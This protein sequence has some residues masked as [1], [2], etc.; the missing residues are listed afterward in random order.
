MKNQYIILLC[1]VL[2]FNLP[3][4]LHA[5]VT[6][7][8]DAAPNENALLEL[9]EDGVTTKGLLMPRVNLNSLTDPSPLT[10]HVEGIIVYNLNTTS[11]ISP[12]L[13]KNDGTRWERMQLPGNGLTGQVLEMD[14]VTMSPEWVTKYIPPAQEL[15]AYSLTKTEAFKY[16][17]GARLTANYS[18]QPY[19]ENST[20]ND[21]QWTK[22][23]NDITINVKNADNKI[24]IFLQTTLLQPGYDAGNSLSYAGGIFVNNALKG[25]RLGVISSSA[26]GAGAV[27]KTETLFFVLEDLTLGDNVLSFAF[28]RRTATNGVTALYIG[29]NMENNGVVYQ[30]STSLSYEFY[31]KK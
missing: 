23:I 14:P 31:E 8:S 30:G 1:S 4:S 21:G 3:W 10:E 19:N 16:T 15:G 5:Q 11:Q 12:G 28:K 25:V 6:I 7:G 13:Y 22:I 29:E 27:S 18:G 20:I 24:I 17:I 2:L 9:R 26:N